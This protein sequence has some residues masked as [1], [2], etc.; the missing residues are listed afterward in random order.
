MLNVEPGESIKAEAIQNVRTVI[1][2][3]DGRSA[4]WFFFSNGLHITMQYFR[5]FDTGE[6][7]TH[8]A[9]R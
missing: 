5:V 1:D 7:W 9:Q 3:K 2:H 4:D 6:T 8:K